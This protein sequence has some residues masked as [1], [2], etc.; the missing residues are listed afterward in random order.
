MADHLGSH[1]YMKSESGRLVVVVSTR[2]DDYMATGSKPTLLAC[3]NILQKQVGTNVRINAGQSFTHTGIR[4]RLVGDG[5]C[6]I[7]DQFD[8]AAP[9][10]LLTATHFE[11]LSDDPP[12]SGGS[13]CLFSNSGWSNRMAGADTTG[14]CYLCEFISAHCKEAGTSGPE[15]R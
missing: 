4:H 13:E 9:I 12:L 14:Y 6:I 5:K 10:K 2:M 11:K 15:A 8:Y 3:H 7:L 1:G